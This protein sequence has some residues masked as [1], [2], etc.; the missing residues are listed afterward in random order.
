MES[1][2]HA[3]EP[4]YHFSYWFLRL[5][6]LGICRIQW[7]RKNWRFV[8]V[9]WVRCYRLNFHHCPIEGPSKRTINDNRL[10]EMYTQIH[11]ERSWWKFNVNGTYIVCNDDKG[12]IR[13][14]IGNASSGYRWNNFIQTVSLETL[15]L[16]HYKKRRI[17]KVEHTCDTF[18]C[19]II[20]NVR[21]LFG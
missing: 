2:A 11:G 9:A 15:C 1:R 10:I 7:N 19:L 5:H 3:I 8:I 21:L 20:C 17:E 18:F 16:L 14:V 4:S 6:C 13:R 12:M